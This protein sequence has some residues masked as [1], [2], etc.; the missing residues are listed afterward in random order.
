MVRRYISAYPYSEYTHENT[1]CDTVQPTKF[2]P[3]CYFYFE[4][5]QLFCCISL[6]YRLPIPNIQISTTDKHDVHFLFT[7]QNFV[8]SSLSALASTYTI[9]LNGVIPVYTIRLKCFRRNAPP[10]AV[11]DICQL[12]F[13][14]AATYPVLRMLRWVGWK[15]VLGQT[16]K[17][18]GDTHFKKG[19]LSVER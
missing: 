1:I 17:L 5:K 19:Q 16:G 18:C 2:T 6:W 4:E 12:R 8:V 10:T 15:V 13:I 11:P 7:C 14:G 9:R 3:S